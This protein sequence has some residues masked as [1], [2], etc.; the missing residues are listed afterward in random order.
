[1]IDG[2]SPEETLQMNKQHRL[3]RLVLFI[4][5]K[6][7]VMLRLDLRDININLKVRTFP[8]VAKLDAPHA[9]EAPQGR[10]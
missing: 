9:G 3:N 8:V 1:L 6:R 7:D 2:Q 10:L 4:T 5:R